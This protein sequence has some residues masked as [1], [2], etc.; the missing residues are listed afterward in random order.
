MS[1]EQD[2][3][4]IPP[5]LESF[6]FEAEAF[7]AE[8]GT[9]NVFVSF[10]SFRNEA[11]LTAVQKARAVHDVEGARKGGEYALKVFKND[12]N[13]G[14]EVSDYEVKW[15]SI[16]QSMNATERNAFVGLCYLIW[17]QVTDIVTLF[18]P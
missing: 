6:T 13:S 7:I 10:T 3:T 11:T 4:K 2:Q 15:W 16:V 14:P 9:S 12:E 5:E 17:P 18:S 8:G 1:Q